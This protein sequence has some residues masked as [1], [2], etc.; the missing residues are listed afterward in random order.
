MPI[1]SDGPRVPAVLLSGNHAAVAR[2]RRE[3]SLARTAEA[4]PDLLAAF[5]KSG[6]LTAADQKFLWQAGD[7]SR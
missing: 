3:Q 7:R 1:R 6:R 2:W 5:E 4:R